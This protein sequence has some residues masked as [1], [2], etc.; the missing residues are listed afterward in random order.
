MPKNPKNDFIKKQAILEN[1]QCLS[2]GTL[3]YSGSFFIDQNHLI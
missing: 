1:V 3:D 2:L